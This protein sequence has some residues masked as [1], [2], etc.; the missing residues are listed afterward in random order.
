[1]TVAQRLLG[2]IAG[3]DFDAFITACGFCYESY[4]YITGIFHPRSFFLPFF[5]PLSRF[6]AISVT[7]LCLKHN[8]EQIFLGEYRGGVQAASVLCW[9]V[10][11]P[12]DSFFFSCELELR[13]LCSSDTLQV[14]TAVKAVCA[15]LCVYMCVC[16]RRL[17]CMDLWSVGR[18]GL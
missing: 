9:R 18:P 8:T 7:T 4:T 5:F 3:L 12:P 17:C 6:I 10:E 14:T 11:E 16:G 1:M 15:C 13:C 2:T